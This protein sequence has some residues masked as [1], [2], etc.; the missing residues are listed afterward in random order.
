[1][2]EKADPVQVCFT[3]HLRDQQSICMQDG[4]KVYMDPYMA[5]NGSCLMVTWSIFKTHL[6]EVGLTQNRETMALRMLTTVHLFYSIMCEN[7]HEQ[8]FIKILFGWRPRHIWLHTALEDPDHTTW[9]WRCLWMTFGHFLVGFH[10]FMV[11]ALGSCVKLPLVLTL[12]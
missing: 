10:D 11:T 7:M 3:L 4:C 8:N 1:M 12:F 5:S 2:V 9:F 6:L